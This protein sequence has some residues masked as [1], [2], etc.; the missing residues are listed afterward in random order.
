MA[1]KW[2]FDKSVAAIGILVLSPVF[3]IVAIAIWA[4]DRGPILYKQQRVGKN[5]QPFT[6]YKFRSMRVQ[7]DNNQLLTIGNDSRITP[8]G[9]F[10]RQY[11]IDELP[12][13]FNVL[14]GS[15]SLVGPRPEVAKYVNLYS[16]SQL[17]VLS[18]K[19]GITDWASIKYSNESELLAKAE[20]PE[21]FYVSTIMPDKLTL[22]LE[23]IKNQSFF[24]DVKIVI[25][26]IFKVSKH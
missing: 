23:Y 5:Q 3:F 6:L 7:P 22:N 18:V 25:N 11:K 13:L 2:L 21:E 20:N 8:I 19:P 9:R 10:I 4:T 12:Q 15:M 24:L 14:N 1:I 26:T 16:T 17:K